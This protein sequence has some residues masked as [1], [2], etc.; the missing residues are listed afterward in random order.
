MTVD[1]SVVVE[2]CVDVTVVVGAVTVDVTVVTGAVTVEVTV[3]VVV[4]VVEKECPAS[5]M[6]HDAAA[7]PVNE[8]V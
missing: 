7:V 8:T 3:V 2:V 4:D 5:T 1:V 6:S